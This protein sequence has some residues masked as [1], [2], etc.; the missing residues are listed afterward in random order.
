MRFRSDLRGFTGAEKALLITFALAIVALVGY[1][2]QAGSGKAGS[3]AR[4][5]LEAGQGALG[6]IGG[7]GSMAGPG[8]SPQAKGEPAPRPPA[9][10][11]LPSG[12]SESGYDGAVVGAGGQAYPPGTP[13]SQVAPVQPSG[14]VRNNEI[15][16][17]TNGISNTKDDQAKTMQDIADT[18]GSQVLG[19]HN[20]TDGFVGDVTQSLGDKLDLG[21]NPAVDTLSD[22]VYDALEAGQPIHLVGHS[23]GALITSRAL[24][25]VRQR[26]MIEDGLTAEQAEQKMS[27]IKVETFGGAAGSYPDGPQYV[28]YV[29]RL[30]PVPDAFGLG[31]F[32][33]NGA[34]KGAKIIR[35]QDPGT[36][37]DIGWKWPPVSVHTDVHGMSAIYL[38]HR[39]PFEEARR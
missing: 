21:R 14:G 24:Y 2:V 8:G 18:T 5:T 32:G 37:V 25:A 22:A 3:D 28:H 29:N 10:T 15:L 26:L 20:S 13:L 1:L 19:I 30:D 17:F 16:I 4:R 7:A 34:G 12:T 9:P 38:K 11:P 35:F 36:S 33:S 6:P 23:Q 39:I 27:S 31:P